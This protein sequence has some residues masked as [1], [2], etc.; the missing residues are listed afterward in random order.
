LAD[1]VTTTVTGYT[2]LV[3]DV[4]VLSC[5]VLEAVAP[6]DSLTSDPAGQP[7]ASSGER[8]SDRPKFVSPQLA[9]LRLVIDIVRP[10]DPPGFIDDWEGEIVSVGATRVHGGGIT[11]IA[12]EAEARL[13][14][15]PRS[16]AMID[17]R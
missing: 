4:E 13:P 7:A 14:D 5:R 1:S 8:L 12:A 3:V 17:A 6:G 15:C 11:T 10:T 9:L 2:P 16:V